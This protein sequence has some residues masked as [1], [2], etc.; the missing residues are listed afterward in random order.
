[1]QKEREFLKKE[2][3]TDIYLEK[4]LFNTYY[5]N[6]QKALDALGYEKACAKD[7]TA[8][9][10][11]SIKVRAVGFNFAVTKWLES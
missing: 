1:M 6:N 5:K 7:F 9:Q 10:E 3:K 2:N 4:I 8:N 11:C